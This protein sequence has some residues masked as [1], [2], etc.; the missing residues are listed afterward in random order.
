M[1]T[2]AHSSGLTATL[3]T[4]ANTI[5]TTSK[6]TLGPMPR[7]LRRIV[8]LPSV[9]PTEKGAGKRVGSQV[10]GLA[11]ERIG[12]LEPVHGDHNPRGMDVEF[13]SHGTNPL[14]E[15]L[16]QTGLHQP[17]EAAGQ[18]E[19]GLVRETRLVATVRSSRRR[20]TAGA[21]RIE[22]LAALDQGRGH[23]RRSGVDRRPDRRP[24][25]EQQDVGDVV[26]QRRDRQ[27]LDRLQADRLE[28]ADDRNLSLAVHAREQPRTSTPGERK[29]AQGMLTDHP[30][31]QTH[32]SP[33]RSLALSARAP[34]GRAATSS[35]ACWSECSSDTAT[36][37][38]AAG[39]ATRSAACHQPR[40]SPGFPLADAWRDDGGFP[41]RWSGRA[42]GDPHLSR[43]GM[44][45]AAE[46]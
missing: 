29:G 33:H 36:R 17:V 10:I 11:D 13:L 42:T 32:R 3:P 22:R 35:T 2:S 16:R 37:P 5:R 44:T 38:P 41:V 46:R 8:T 43:G 28:L 31:Q 21:Q 19:H 4:N 30:R 26:D 39:Y 34:P 18:Y 25:V 15:G 9:A 45:P 23:A 24:L 20:R 40:A 7:I 6:T 14:F 1:T 12:S 27:Q